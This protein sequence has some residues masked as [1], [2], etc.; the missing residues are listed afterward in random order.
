[1]TVKE[2]TPASSAIRAVSANVGA[3]AAGSAGV[4]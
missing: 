1:M 4:E 3:I 2:E